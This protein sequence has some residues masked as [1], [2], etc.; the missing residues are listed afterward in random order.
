MGKA[1]GLG[2]ALVLMGLMVAAKPWERVSLPRMGWGPLQRAFAVEA[3]EFEGVPQ[4]L[5]HEL[6]AAIGFVPGAAWSPI[7]AQRQAE[8]LVEKFGWIEQAAP[9][10]SWTGRRVRFVVVPRAAV[11]LVTGPRR[12]G[13]SPAWLSEDGKVFAAPA[14]MVDGSGLPR[15][16]LAGWPDGA[17]LSGAAVLVRTVAAQGGLPSAPAAYSYDA[18]ERGWKVELADG[19]RILWGGTD[20]TTEKLARLG[21]VFADALPR[22]GPGFTADLRYFEDG[23]IL[24]R[25]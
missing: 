17:D 7:A 14:G 22:L 18:R 8:R 1:A 16:E 15:V 13:D 5:A 24:V 9:V 6:E 3:V 4:G 11:A 23:R 21:E 12:G 2:S 20:W 10:R 25:P 19:T